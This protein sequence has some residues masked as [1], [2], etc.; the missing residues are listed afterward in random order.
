MK[1]DLAIPAPSSFGTNTCRQ[2]TSAI[3][4]FSLAEFMCNDQRLDGEQAEFFAE[5]G[6]TILESVDWKQIEQGPWM[7]FVVQSRQ[8][9]LAMKC[10]RHPSDFDDVTFS[11]VVVRQGKSSI[12][13]L[14]MTQYAGVLK[15]NLDLF[16]ARLTELLQCSHSQ[17][18]SSD[19]EKVLKDVSLMVNTFRN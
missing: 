1:H 13:H 15:S 6:R 4:S 2:A 18:F 10:A 16:A 7:S 17:P 19:L 11:S 3:M 5:I 9:S 12:D 8:A 14:P